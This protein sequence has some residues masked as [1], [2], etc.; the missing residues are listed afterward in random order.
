MH[1][2]PYHITACHASGRKLAARNFTNVVTLSQPLNEGE[3]LKH[4]VDENERVYISSVHNI[5]NVEYNSLTTYNFSTASAVESIQ[6]SKL[7]NSEGY[8]AES[9]NST[10]SQLT[11]PE[12][13]YFC[14]DHLGNIRE[15]WQGNRRTV[16]QRKQY[17][18]SGLP[19]AKNSG[20]DTELPA[21]ANNRK[22][23]GK[24]WVEMHGLD[25][26]DSEAR[27]YY[28]AIM[29]TTTID[30][31][32]EM[33]YSIS[34]YAW[35]GNNPVNAIDPDGCQIVGIT[36]DDALKVQQD[37][38]TM[39][40]GDKFGQFRGL[41]TLDKMGTVFNS[42]STEAI[43]SAFE[44]ITL[45]VDEQALVNEVVGAINSESVHKVEYVSIDGSVSKEGTTAFRTHLNN[46]Q[47]GAGDAM[48]PSANMPGATMNAVSGGG[49]NIP[50][51]NGSHSVIMEGKGIVHDGGRAITTGHE[52]IGHG[53]AS[54]NKA[55]PLENNTRA[56]RV[57]NLMRR[58]MGITT[59]R[60]EH[61]GAVIVNPFALP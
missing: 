39:F 32:A 31:L 13:Y 10:S 18:P 44:G 23:N 41:F 49:L 7:Y 47:K 16:V 20:D 17:Y 1:F 28:P 2:A 55:T 12:Y 33:Y 25:E 27:W 59:F 60:T 58:V 54:A 40:A 14:R 9:S 15:V 11:N 42:I 35:C 45:S 6:F 29:R 8:V 30:P 46:V 4:V 22:Y 36:K 43:N 26:Y 56:I 34:P 24:E 53:V 19:W 61:G 52:I 37:I 57:D 5:D 48:I 51:K 3:V 50:T 21:N 38:N